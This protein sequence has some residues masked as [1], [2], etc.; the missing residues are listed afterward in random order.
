[1]KAYKVK[2]GIVLENDLSFYL[3]ENEDWDRFFNDDDILDR[4]LKTVKALHPVTNAA[5]YLETELEAPVKSQEI[6]ASGVTYYNSKL[7]REEESKEAGG[8]NFYARVYEAER[9]ELFFK[10]MGYRA[11]P[12]G[13]MVRKRSDSAWDVPEPE[14]TLCITSSGKIIGYT[15]GNDMSSRSIEG[16]N[17][18]YLPQAK[19]YDGSTALGPCILLTEQ[20]LPGTTK[21]RIKIAR[22]GEEV[23]SGEI[24]IDQIKRRFEDLVH[25]QYLEYSFPHGSLLMTGTGIVPSSEFNLSKG[26]EILITIDGIGQLVNTVA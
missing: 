25:Y 15:I 21:I 4:A 12:S 13:G 19:C 11:V 20:P 26:D 10:A 3:L 24:G 1:M 18:L 22:Q 17:P 6:W 8:S 23:F 7:G 16:E 9:P 14:L 5:R 2:S